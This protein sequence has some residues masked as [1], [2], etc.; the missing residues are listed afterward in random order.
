MLR[1]SVATINRYRTATEHLLS[2]VGEKSV[3]LASNFHARHAEEFV[4][5]LRAIRVAPNG[6]PH[7]AKRPLLDKGIKYILESCRALF[8]YALRRRHLSPY[9]ENPFSALQIERIPIEDA[10]PIVLLTPDQERAFLEACDEWQFPLFLT[11]MLTGLRPGELTHLLLPDDLD[12]AAGVLRVRNKPKLG[13]QVKTRSEREVPLVSSLLGVLRHHLGGRSSGPVFRL[14]RYTGSIAPP[15][16]GMAAARLESELSR[17]IARLESESEGSTGRAGKL[18]VA[19]GVWRDIGAIKEERIRLEFVRVTRAIGLP[20]ATAP[21]AAA[22]PVRH[23][24]PGG[25]GRPAGAERAHGAFDDVREG[26]RTGYDGRLHA[27]QAGDAKGAARV[28]PAV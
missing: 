21:E 11:L 27:H 7:T 20:G 23:D 22:P 14:R 16:A 25:Q 8:G 6:H 26:R 19:R 5:H 2:F 12:L 10:R 15:L 4:R 24:P 13:W 1:S 28:G 18:A 9:A 17:R 3:R